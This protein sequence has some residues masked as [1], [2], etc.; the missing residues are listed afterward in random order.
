MVSVRDVDDLRGGENPV[1]V[2]KHA[3]THA[4]ASPARSEGL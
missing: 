4:T 1:I 2:R 3:F